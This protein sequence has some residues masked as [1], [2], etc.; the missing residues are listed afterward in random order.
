MGIWISMIE[1]GLTAPYGFSVILT[2]N[3]T[4]SAIAKFLVILD[5]AIHRRYRIHLQPMTRQ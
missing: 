3:C 4:V 1:M 2:R 5:N